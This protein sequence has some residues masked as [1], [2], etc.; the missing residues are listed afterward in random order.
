V[1]ALPDVPA[2]SEAVRGY[3][4]TPWYGLFVPAGT[5]APIIFRIHA[6]VVKALGAKDLQDKMLAQGAEPTHSTPEQFAALIN[7][8]LPKWAQIVKASGMQLD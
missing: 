7:A 5:P 1:R 8:E 6:E 2:V 4:S 3:G